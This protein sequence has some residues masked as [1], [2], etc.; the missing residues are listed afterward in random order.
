MTAGYGVPSLPSAQKSSSPQSLTFI[1]LHEVD[2]DQY[3]FDA[4]DSY[5]SEEEISPTDYC[6]MVPLDFVDSDAMFTDD[7]SA[8]TGSS[9]SSAPIEDVF[10]EFDPRVAVIH[11]LRNASTIT[12][13]CP[14]SELPVPLSPGA[15]SDF[16]WN[17]IANPTFLLSTRN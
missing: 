15:T 7:T 6:F 3:T 10:D 5:Y 2:V 14:V 9:D 17:Q 13:D 4:V 16:D 1:D 8:T 11:L 12:V